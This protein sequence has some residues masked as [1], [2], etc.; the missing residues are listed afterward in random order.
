MKNRIRLLLLMV[1]ICAC[2]TL[3]NSDI[4]P[5]AAFKLIPENGKTIDTFQFDASLTQ[6]DNLKNK[7][8]YRWDWNRD[9][10]WDEEFTHSPVTR[11][12]YYAKGTYYPKL[13]VIN[14]G[15]MTD[16]ISAVVTVEQGY[17]AP[18]PS[19]TVTPESGNMKTHY[20]L[21]ASETKDDEDSLRQLR[22][23]WDFNGNGEWDTPL[24]SNPVITFIYPDTGKYNI[25]VEAVDPRNLRTRTS[26]SVWVTNINPRLVA[27]FNWTPDYGTTATLFTFD[28]SLSHN[29][30]DPQALFR[31][32]WKLPP[33]YKW[34]DWTYKSDTTLNFTRED[35]YD[36]EL[37]VKDTAS[38]INY[39]K[40]TIRIYHNNTPPSP[41]FIIGCRR[42]NI[43]TQFFFNSWPTLDQ[44]SLP[45]TLEVRWDFNGD[46][47]WDTDYSKERKIY[48]NYPEP[49]TYKVYME[50][51]DPDGLSDTTAQ[52]VEVSP[53]TNETG[54]IFDQRDG[55][56]YGS[57]KI[58]D[59]WWMSQN[60]NFRPP[61]Y[62]KDEVRRWCYRRWDDDPVAWCNIMGG[63]Y[64]CYHA[65][66]EDY[67]G[68]VTGI[69]PFGWH[70][71]S[72]KEWEKL[73]ANIGGWDQADKLLP[74]GL[75]D[76]NAL[77]SGFM[78]VVSV[79]YPPGG[80][81]EEFKWL[82]YGTYF[83][84]FN[85]MPDPYSPNSWNLTLI[86]G[87]KKFHPGWSAMDYYY[88]VRC[89]KN[90]E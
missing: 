60:L 22:F 54:L 17:S 53:W 55:Q 67:Y 38:L 83:W 90:E 25:I 50:A 76:F 61:D 77:Y 2:N 10:I 40:K 48:H 23:M 1:N 12:R 56:Y 11:H 44:E 64:N 75:T 86:K 85:K 69:C 79:P 19:F 80:T 20:I 58:G 71:P 68:E 34:S 24:S 27:D 89:V 31:Y 4:P 39:S 62:H 37:R 57:V 13:E 33:F 73:V 84:S 8:Y 88:S 5:V 15:G 14:S 70:M 49:G 28:G 7:I 81:K 41:K 6:S 9:G 21:D 29:L 63:L 30:D 46:K 26:R 32:S 16:T 43:R 65:T 42:G 66:R 18:H 45:T 36:I 72:R 35:N 87:E 3:Y 74:G 82:D 47:T 59:Q 51:L 52:F 78:A